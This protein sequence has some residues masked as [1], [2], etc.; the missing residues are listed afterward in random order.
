MSRQIEQS[1]L[2]SGKPHVPPV[3]RKVSFI[4]SSILNHHL[5]KQIPLFSVGHPFA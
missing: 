2:S 3:P 4:A 5:K 1:Q